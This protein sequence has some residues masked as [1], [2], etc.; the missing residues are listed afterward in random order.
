MQLNHET[1][2][3]NPQAGRFASCHQPRP[4]DSQSI[5]SPG[6]TSSTTFLLGRRARLANRNQATQRVNQSPVTGETN[7]PDMRLMRTTMYSI[8]FHLGS[9]LVKRYAQPIWS[10]PLPTMTSC[11]R[12][13]NSSKSHNFAR[14]NLMPSVVCWMERTALSLSRLDTEKV[15]DFSSSQNC[16]KTEQ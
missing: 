14:N 8:W 6:N 11:R 4:C 2:S 16:T 3:S 9:A 1:K 10:A 12:E 5:P 7:V 15:F 13:P